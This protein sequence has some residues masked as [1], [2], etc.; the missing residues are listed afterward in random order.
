[1]KINE[2]VSAYI[3]IFSIWYI[4]SLLEVG[5]RADQG[6]CLGWKINPGMLGWL[7]LPSI[8]LLWLQSPTT[9]RWVATTRGCT[10]YCPATNT[11]CTYLLIPNHFP[12]CLVLIYVLRFTN[13]LFCLT[14]IGRVILKGRRLITGYY[15]RFSLQ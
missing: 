9:D 15:L 3:K 11:P 10:D 12:I 2:L 13:T 1:M 7:R 14:L 5:C 8:S 4:L 6:F